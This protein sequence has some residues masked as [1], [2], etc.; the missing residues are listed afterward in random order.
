M[1]GGVMLMKGARA[2]V[3]EEGETFRQ[4]GQITAGTSCILTAPSQLRTLVPI[5][6]SAVAS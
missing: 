2:Q 6:V 5:H 3:V 1:G 4:E